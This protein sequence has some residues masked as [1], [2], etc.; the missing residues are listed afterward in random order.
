MQRTDPFVIPEKN[1][2]KDLHEF[3]MIRVLGYLYG[4]ILS[5]FFSRS[6]QSLADLEL[7]VQVLERDLQPVQSKFDDRISSLEM[8]LRTSI[9]DLKT[10]MG[11]GKRGLTHH[12][13][14]DSC[15]GSGGIIEYLTRVH[16]R[17]IHDANVVFASASHPDPDDLWPVK[18]LLDIKAD[19]SFKSTSDVDQWFQI[20]FK[21]MQIK[22]T[23]YAMQ[24]P[25]GRVYPVSWVI[26]ASPSGEPGSWIQLDSQ[27]SCSEL[28]DSSLKEFPITHS[29]WYRFIRFRQTGM[30]ASKHGIVCLKAFEVYGDL[31][32]PAPD[33]D[34]F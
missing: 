23:H 19:S 6:Q 30:N 8:E 29:G 14:S 13:P 20:D 2:L 16:G 11:R 9:A 10:A 32:T 17:N 21:T 22:P 18:H 1:D 7:R 27:Q 34:E 25:A 33:G 28:K 26:E 31:E 4:S 24:I 12:F 3:D 15:N 5:G